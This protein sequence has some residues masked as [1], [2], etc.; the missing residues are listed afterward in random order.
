[1]S[2]VSLSS[3]TFLIR[4]VSLLASALT[5]LVF[6]G[7]SDDGLG[8]RYSVYGTVT[9][10]GTPVENGT[11]TF[12]LTGGKDADARGASGSINNGSYTLS[13]IGGDDGAFP[14][15]YVVAISA[16]TPDFSQAK[17]NQAKTGGS[18]RQDDVAKAYKTAPSPIPTKYESTTT[19][20]L[21]AKVE[22]RSNKI[23]FPLT[24]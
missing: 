6:V 17:A 5:L 19:S 9:Y 8:K 11:I 3:R 7:C 22:A 24:D 14:G 4:G 13:T 10:K 20:G 16:R 18:M 15:D 23:D 2:H 21:K 12:Y 1:M